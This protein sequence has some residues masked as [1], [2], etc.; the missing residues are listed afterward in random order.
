MNTLT[1][2]DYN[3]SKNINLLVKIL[4]I[5]DASVGKSSILLRYTNDIHTDEYLST[6]GLDFK[7]KTIKM[8]NVNIKLQLWDTAGQERYRTLTSSFLR[9]SHA[10]II[11]YDVTNEDSFFNIKNWMENIHQYN[12]N[13]EVFLVANKVDSDDR[14]IS[15]ENGKK[16]AEKYNILFFECSAK[17]GYN[18]NETFET[19]ADIVSKKLLNKI[20]NNPLSENKIIDITKEPNNFEKFKRKCC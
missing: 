3:K 19:I 16:L 7:I 20:I 1:I 11:T 4:I 2:N 17:S 6:I 15:T 5:G 9:S 14:I 12:N 13:G 18:I 8:N 10:V